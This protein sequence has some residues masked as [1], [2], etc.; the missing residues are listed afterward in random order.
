VR[1]LIQ[2]AG[3][4]I[5]DL[6][7]EHDYAVFQINDPDTDGKYIT[8]YPGDIV[9]KTGSGYIVHTTTENQSR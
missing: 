1:D 8:L 3:F 5:S 4:K 6:T 2:T 7:S 9:V